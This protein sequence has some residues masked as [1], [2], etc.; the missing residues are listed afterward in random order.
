VAS[1]SS[2]FRLKAPRHAGVEWDPFGFLLE[3]A[4]PSLENTGTE[5]LLWLDSG[6]S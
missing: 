5:R 6:H 1:F 2:L 3:A 4:D